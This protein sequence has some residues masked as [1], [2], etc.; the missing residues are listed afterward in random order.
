MRTVD[1]GVRTA[2]S[3]VRTVDS[4]VRTADYWVMASDSVLRTAVVLNSVLR[5][6]QLG[7][8]N[9]RDE[10]FS[11]IIIMMVVVVV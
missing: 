1:S 8:R 11:R 9:P 5:I 6:A 2:D 7:L 4:G 10:K 3:G